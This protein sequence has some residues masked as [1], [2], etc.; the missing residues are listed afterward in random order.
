MKSPALYSQK[1]YKSKKISFVVDDRVGFNSDGLRKNF[2]YS[3]KIVTG[4]KSWE[5]LRFVFGLSRGTFQTYQYGYNLIPKHL[6]EK[7]NNLLEEEKQILFNNS[8][9]IKPGN[10]GAKKGGNITFRK[11]PEICAKGRAIAI[12]MKQKSCL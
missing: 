5:K 9:F 12:K 4:V 7:M 2:F 1:D 6:F 3:I 10:W 11:H 8:I